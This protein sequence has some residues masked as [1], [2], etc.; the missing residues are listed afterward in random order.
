[1]PNSA[2]VVGPDYIIPADLSFS[3]AT[4]GDLKQVL[5]DFRLIHDTTE[6]ITPTTAAF[7]IDYLTP[8]EID[9]DAAVI[10]D[11]ITALE[12]GGVLD[13]AG[14][15]LSVVGPDYLAPQDP[16]TSDLAG[17]LTALEA[18]GYLNDTD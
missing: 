10:G 15:G 9:L 16:A 17:V 7:S 14:A 4:L 2:G 12:S 3:T 13:D 11:V 1:M 8:P 6:T 18:A 5:A